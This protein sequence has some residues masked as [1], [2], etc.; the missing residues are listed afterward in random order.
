MSNEEGQFI[1]LLKKWVIGGVAS[2]ISLMVVSMFWFY[3]SANGRLKK[4]EDSQCVKV[5]ISDFNNYKEYQQ[6][7]DTYTNRSLDEIKQDLKDIKNIL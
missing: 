4:L 7:K 6:L 1:K 3:T 5:D 2:I